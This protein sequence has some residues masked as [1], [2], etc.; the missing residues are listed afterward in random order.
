MKNVYFICYLLFYSAWQEEKIS[1]LQ[2][3]QLELHIPIHEAIMAKWRG[4]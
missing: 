1:V 4:S 2:G 3:S